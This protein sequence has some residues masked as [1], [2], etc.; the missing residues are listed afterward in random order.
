MFCVMLG[1]KKKKESDDDQLSTESL[2]CQITAVINDKPLSKLKIR[3]QKFE[4]RK[5]TLKQTSYKIPSL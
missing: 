5:K 3:L 2:A 1:Q 4:N